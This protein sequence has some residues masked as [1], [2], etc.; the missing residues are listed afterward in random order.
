MRDYMIQQIGLLDTIDVT[1]DDMLQ[2]AKYQPI[3]TT[4]SIEVDLLKI[5]GQELLENIHRKMRMLGL[6]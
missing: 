4:D 6:L 5:Q 3:Q 2:V 1:L